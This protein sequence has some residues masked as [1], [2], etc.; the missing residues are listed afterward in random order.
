MRES[1]RTEEFVMDKAD[2][3][4]RAAV[5]L[6]VPSPG[7]SVEQHLGARVYGRPRA[8]GSAALSTLALSKCAQLLGSLAALKQMR[9]RA[10]S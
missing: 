10:H 9:K 4:A 2:A 3:R 7:M 1:G 5:I 8:G 6:D